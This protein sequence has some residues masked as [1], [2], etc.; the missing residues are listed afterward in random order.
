[1]YSTNKWLLEMLQIILSQEQGENCTQNFY[2]I[3]CDLRIA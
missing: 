1:M 2:E 3:E